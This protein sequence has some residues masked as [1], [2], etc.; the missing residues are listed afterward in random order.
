MCPH[1]FV[2]GGRAG[3]D[4]HLHQLECVE[5]TA[6]AGLSVGDNRGEP[7]RAVAPFA[8]I[9]LIGA[10]QRLID[11][12]DDLRNRIRRIQTLIGIHLAGEIRIGRDLPSAEVNRLQAGAHLL[13]RLVAGERA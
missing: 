5:T 11:P 12:L 1:F 13:H 7:M 9:D 4:H 2:N 3:L 8:V 6:E 10:L